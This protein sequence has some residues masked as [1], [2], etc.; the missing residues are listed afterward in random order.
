MPNQLNK[1]LVSKI[2]YSSNECKLYLQFTQLNFLPWALRIASLEW[3]HPRWIEERIIRAWSLR[4]RE[5]CPCT[6]RALHAGTE[7]V[8]VR[9]RQCKY[10]CGHRQ[11]AG[12]TRI[13]CSMVTP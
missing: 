12:A 5:A 4:E 11:E 3:R 9:F 1:I 2:E 8:R 10:F 6:V 13:E 7:S